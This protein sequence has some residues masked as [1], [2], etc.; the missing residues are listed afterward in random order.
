MEYLE[1]LEDCYFD[2]GYGSERCFTPGARY[3]ILDGSTDDMMG[4]VLRDD[5]GGE[6]TISGQW[7]NRF[8]ALPLIDYSEQIAA[9]RKRE[10]IHEDLLWDKPEQDKQFT[11]TTTV[12]EEAPTNNPRPRDTSWVSI[13]VGTIIRDDDF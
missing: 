3:E 6:H 4:V 13:P 9:R 7:A 12:G 2:R 10:R 5:Q 8:V 11:W 1:C